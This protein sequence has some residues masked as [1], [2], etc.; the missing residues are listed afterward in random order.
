MDVTDRLVGQM[1]RVTSHWKPSFSCSKHTWLAVGLISVAEDP[2][3]PH[4]LFLNARAVPQ[5]ENP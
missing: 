4:V 5:P 1:Y 2:A 3:G